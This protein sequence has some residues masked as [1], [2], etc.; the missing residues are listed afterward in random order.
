M[1]TVTISINGTPLITRSAVRVRD[2]KPIKI[3][4]EEEI[5]HSAYKLDDGKEIFHKPEDGPVELAKKML[6]QVD[7]KFLELK[8]DRR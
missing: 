6:D 1:I 7:K 5:Q 4:K 3:G 2:L 8:N